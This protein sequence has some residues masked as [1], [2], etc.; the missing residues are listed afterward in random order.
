MN[1]RSHNQT[2]LQDDTN[3]MSQTASEI[4]QDFGKDSVIGQS[5][6]KLA[7]AAEKASAAFERLIK[8]GEER[9]RQ[10]QA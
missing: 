1:L 3:A 7:E 9:Q 2:T 4:V 5:Y 6:L 10:R 8:F